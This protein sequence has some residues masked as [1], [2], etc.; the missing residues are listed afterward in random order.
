MERTV[1]TD[2]R[3][4]SLLIALSAMLLAFITPN[5]VAKQ[6]IYNLTIIVDITR[7]MNAMD[8]QQGDKAVSRLTFVKHSLH[9]LLAT[10]PC[11]SK[12]SLGVFTERR[13]TL[14]FQPI[15]VCTGFN[16]I[17]ATLA[18]LDWRSAW[19]ADSRIAQGLKQTLDGLKNSDSTL[20]FM[21]DGQEAPPV[22]PRYAVDFSAL[23]TKKKGLIVGV[24][25][26]QAVPIPKFNEKGESI[27]FYSA[28]DV[29]HRSS[30]GESNL[31]PETI[32]GYDARNAPF[33]KAAVSGT[34][35]LSALQESYL[36][37]IATALGFHYTRLTDTANLKQALQDAHIATL[38]TVVI[39]RRWQFATL[40]LSLLM[41]IYL[42]PHGQRFT[43]K[44]FTKFR[45]A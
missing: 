33:G 13:S 31:N 25:G 41:C 30:F 18:A 14:L 5:T 43:L 19:A 7:S 1:F 10:L 45:R 39:D 34:E 9:E 32:D 38:K 26:L 35:H 15:E 42:L 17:D 21:T 3:F 29:P 23:A 24:G 11:Q 40:A 44:Y 22:N 16:E 4:Y 37:N 8:Y 12:V 20:V 28:D 6:P 27:G 36:Q 2:Y